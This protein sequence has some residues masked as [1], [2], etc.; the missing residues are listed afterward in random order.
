MDEITEVFTNIEGF[1]LTVVFSTIIA[2]HL[3]NKNLKRSDTLHGFRGFI[4][5][6]IGFVMFNTY[7][8][9]K[10]VW[11]TAA[12]F[13]GLT[14]GLIAIACFALAKDFLVKKGYLKT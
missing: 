12:L 11:T 8:C 7:V 10:S 6:C 13:D 2:S 1:N 5:L 14:N 4:P 3:I 9:T